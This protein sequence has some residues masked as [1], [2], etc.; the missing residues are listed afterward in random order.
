M[1][2]LKTFIFIGRSG[3]GKGTQVEKLA[4]H[5][6]EKGVINAEHAWL[7]IETGARFRE[8]I[9][10][11]NYTA[12]V[13]KTEVEQGKRSPENF[14]IWIWTGL[15][16]DKFTGAEHIFCDGC[17]RSLPE[18]EILDM[19]LKFY[20][21]EKP[22][23]FYLDVSR[24]ETKRRLLERGRADDNVED[25]E[26]RLDWFDRDVSPAVKYY[27]ESPDYTCIRIN[28]EQTREKIHEDIVASLATI[29]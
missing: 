22:I 12:K 18:A 27:E 2:N 26:R 9:K 4:E 28:G 14:A 24:E 5:L 8:I 7:R 10:M 25:I 19:A 21:R 15:L 29:D 3:C 23:V 1:E 17:P 16:F 20:K 11:D 13:L 6:T